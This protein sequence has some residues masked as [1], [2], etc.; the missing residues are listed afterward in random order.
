[1]K[2]IPLI[3]AVM[4]LANAGMVLAQ[5]KKD[6]FVVDPSAKAAD[7]DE[8][9]ERSIGI[10]VEFIKL[11]HLKANE[12]LRI[13]APKGADAQELRDE[14][15]VLIKDESA[16]L[17]ETT[18]IHARSGQRA[19]TESIDEV[20]YPTEWLPASAFNQ[21]QDSQEAASGGLG[22]G[23][24]DQRLTSASQSDT[25]VDENEAEPPNLIPS[26][27][28]TRNVGVTFEVDP[29]LGA[30]GRTIDLSL[31][32][33]LVYHLGDKFLAREGHEETAKGL[34]HVSIPRFYSMKVSTQVTTKDG[35]YVILTILT[36]EDGDDRILVLLRADVI[37]VK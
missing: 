27:F 13:H 12:L 35:N 7:D 6:P 3:L 5:E 8:D 1:M 26:S 23:S 37:V 19:K 36:P 34:E 21:G 9:A 25:S 2:K 11:D 32:P 20:I 16:E 28:E 15:A 17:L 18:W 22:D 24:D 30:D 10:L 29:V 14:L 31:A 33:E 4:F